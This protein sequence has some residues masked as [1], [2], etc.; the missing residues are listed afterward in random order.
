MNMPPPP[1]YDNSKSSTEEV[2]SN[3]FLRREVACRMKR[4]RYS[5]DQRVANP[6]PHALAQNE[7]GY[8]LVTPS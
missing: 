7:W 8:F 2:I 1:P 6:Q 3:R 5:E 4:E